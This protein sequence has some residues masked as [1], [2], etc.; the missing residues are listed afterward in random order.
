MACLFLGVAVQ[1]ELQLFESWEGKTTVDNQPATGV[2]GGWVD[3]DSDG[4]GN[5]SITTGDGI[6]LTTFVNLESNSGGDERGVA[7]SGVNNPIDDGEVGVLFFRFRLVEAA[8]RCYTWFGVTPRNMTSS[9][10][11]AIGEG[12]ENNAFWVMS[13]GFLCYRDATSGAISIRTIAADGVGTE[14]T[15]LN[16]GTTWYD[17]WFD[18]DNGADTFDLYIE[19]SKNPGGLPPDRPTSDPLLDDAPFHYTP[20]LGGLY[21]VLM[22][23]PDDDGTDPRPWS[24][25]SLRSYMDDIYWDGSQGLVSLT[26]NK[27]DPANDAT[28]VAIEKVLSWMAPD[29]P[30]IGIIQGYDVYI[31]PNMTKIANRDP[32]TLKSAAQAG[33]SYDP[34]SNLAFDKTY[35]WCVD[36]T[37]LFTPEIDPNQIP[38]VEAGKV[39]NFRTETPAPKIIQSPASALVDSGQPASF[40]VLADSP[41]PPETYQWYS[42]TDQA[43]NTSADDIQIDGATSTTFT[44]PGVAIADEKYYYCTVSNIYNSVNYKVSSDAAALGIKRNVAYWTLDGLVGGQ[45]PDSSGEGHHA[46]PNGTPVFV[47]GVNPALTNNSVQIDASS[48]WANAG[49]WNPSQYSGQLT[50]SL[51]VK[52]GGQPT[53]PVYQGLI[54]KRNVYASNMMWQ[55]EIGNNA[56]SI[57]TFK[58]NI[59][60]VTSPILPV[61]EWEQVVVTYDGTTATIYRNGTYANSG[62]VT[63]NDGVAANLMIGA[64]GHDP[65]PIPPVTTSVMNGLLDDIKIYNYALDPVTIA[66]SFTDID[67]LGRTACAN[68]NDPVLVKYDLDGNCEVGLSDLADLANHWLTGQLVPDVVDRP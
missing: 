38:V 33:T 3:T 27:P 35:Y 49:T 59:N 21:G 14:I 65:T 18:V 23:T 61:G 11:D 2:L 67:P 68:P 9:S 43:N 31:D 7:V 54:G 10:S 60:G 37:V 34:I 19:P 17:C 44:I 4:S 57:L 45:Y 1:A 52:W 47:A 56:A 32:S 41:S 40:T 39:W 25:R 64:V 12:N 63:L 55:L 8:R 28:N 20:D 58:S 30:A 13:A 29:S 36:T 24:D 5:L 50:I 53:A 26:A 15:T 48:G 46:D 6:N 16:A 51:W 62:P 42:S 66:Y 22:H